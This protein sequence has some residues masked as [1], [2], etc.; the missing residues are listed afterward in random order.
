MLDLQSIEERGPLS[1]QQEEMIRRLRAFPECAPRYDIVSMFELLGPLDAECLIG[2][3]GDA[4]RRH[5][6]LRTTIATEGRD[7]QHIYRSALQDVVC[8]SGSGYSDALKVEL[9][10]QR[11]ETDDVLSG[12]PLFRPQLVKVNAEHHLLILTIHH[13]LIDS[14]SM[15]PLYRDLSVFYEARLHK[16]AAN[17]PDLP[18][19]YLE[20]SV[21]Q[22]RDW[23]ACA[24]SALPFW[25]K[26]TAGAPRHI[27]W[28]Q[29]NTQSGPYE[30]AEFSFVLSP[31]STEVVRR[32]ALATRMTPFLVLFT[33]TSAALA[34]VTEQDDFLLGADFA[35]REALAKQNLVGHFLNSRLIRVKQGRRHSFRDL[36]LATRRAWLDADEYRDVYLDQVLQELGISW[37]PL[38]Q[39]DQSDLLVNPEFS[40]VT[41][42]RIPVARRDPYWREL[43]I[44]WNIG[45]SETSCDMLYLPA[46]ISATSVAAM[47]DEI[48]ATLRLAESSK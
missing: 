17:L 16:R 26:V 43:L 29:R 36:V 22:R 48:E 46:S 37:L 40:G 47:A 24:A 34:Q 42:K 9:L 10:A 25:R 5:A 15:R 33:T 27:S 11:H 4:V 14:L 28:P 30:T 13:L 23:A 12:K 38:V 1:F 18:I 39:D 7:E 6:V 32:I 20:F 31:S 8:R 3:L 19:T 44:T 41:L 35:N 21:R 2:A 45:H